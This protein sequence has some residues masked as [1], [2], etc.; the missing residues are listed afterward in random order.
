MRGRSIMALVLTPDFPA[1]DWL[2][3]LDQQMAR[4]PG[5]FDDRPVILDV[6][7]V[8]EQPDLAG[9]A[10]ALFDRGV[11]VIGTEGAPASWSGL[12]GLLRPLRA[13]ARPPR[14]VAMPEPPTPPPMPPPTPPAAPGLVVEEPVRSGQ[15]VR[16]EAGDV[17]IVGTVASGAEV[18]AGGS[19]HVYGALRGRA[20]AGVAHD[21]SRIFCRRMEAELVAVGGLYLT[22]D[23]V[24]RRLRGRPVQVARQD[25][26]L[27]LTPLD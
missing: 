22:A 12:D 11:R 3:A 25:E 5:F 14:A 21:H 10:Q 23:Q 19:I 17:T 4:S 18:I 2:E 16:F 27:V 24:D 9:L 6:A 26:S 13:S 1:A 20:M 8:R 7:G 15:S